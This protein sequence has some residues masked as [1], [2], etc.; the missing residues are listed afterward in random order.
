MDLKHSDTL[1][2]CT[3]L[4]PVPEVINTRT[5]GKGQARWER[6]KTPNLPS[7]RGNNNIRAPP[8]SHG[9]TGRGKQLA[10]VGARVSKA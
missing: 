2:R 3:A 6:L 1:G 10:I 5:T 4:V 7:A 9:H 8:S